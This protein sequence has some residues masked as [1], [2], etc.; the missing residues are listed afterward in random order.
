MFAAQLTS[1]FST[2]ADLLGAIS[3]I[4]GISIFIGGIFQMKKYGESRTMMS[5]QHSVAGPLMMLLAG[6]MLMA[7]PAVI[8]SAM[9]A[10]WSDQNPL[11][12]EGGPGGYSALIPPVIMFVR[13]I[14]V[15]SFMRGIVLMSRSGSQQSQPGTMAKALIHLLAGVLC[16]HI[17]GTVDLMQNILGL[18]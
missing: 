15:G 13:I 8:D 18:A 4:M 11:S 12:Y 10:F 16:I 7:L 14:G 6:T 1:N 2:I 17:I 3:L 9:L 5:G